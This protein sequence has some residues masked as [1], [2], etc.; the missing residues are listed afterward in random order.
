MA[1]TAKNSNRFTWLAVTIAVFLVLAIF[2]IRS[3]TRTETPVRA[4]KPSY[5]DMLTTSSTNG[6]VE[7]VQNFEAHAPM[8]G[9]IKEVA[10]KE[11][12]LV[13]QGTL[14][15]AM[16][17]TSAEAR[18][19][20]A[21]SALTAAQSSEQDLRSGGTQEERINLSG[22]IDTAQAQVRQA[23][24]DLAA[25]QQLQAKGAASAA[26][27]ESARN[28]LQNAQSNLQ[29]LEAKKTSRY[30]TS[31]QN[32]TAAQLAEGR[33][34][35]TDAAKV[36]SETSVHAPFSGTVYS[37]PF[38]KYD[39]INTGDVLVR[40]ADLTHMQVRAYFDE[41][42][43]GRLAVGQAVAIT[44]DA[45]T[46]KVWHGHIVRTPSTIIT[47]G[48]RNVGECMIAVD[49]ANGDLLPNTNVNVKVTISQKM[50]VLTIPREGLRTQGT[51]NYVYRI[52]KGKL[53]KTPVKVGDVSM[54]LVEIQSGI[55]TDDTIALNATTSADLEPGLEVKPTK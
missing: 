39:Y 14:L 28:R 10:V 50:H 32:R 20:T 41:P 49:D 1:E 33:A 12:A 43:I 55:T 45:K 34:V 4:A 23:R 52:V 6:K 24:Q 42:E 5:E 36:L 48:T 31:D 16:D 8:P 15:V 44:W 38:K 21:R 13:A 47:Y 11:G 46:G 22:Q 26:E 3:L 30:S 9:V 53:E 37:L 18:V 54:T 17:P 7:P 27:V 19:A 35:L 25:L 2:G 40:M 51:K 29:V